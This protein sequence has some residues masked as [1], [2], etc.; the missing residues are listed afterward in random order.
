MSMVKDLMSR[1]VSAESAGIVPRFFSLL[2]RHQIEWR[3]NLASPPDA[4]ILHAILDVEKRAG[5]DG[6]NNL[7]SASETGM[8]G[9]QGD[10]VDYHRR[11]QAKARSKVEKLAVKLTAAAKR[12]EP[13]EE[14]NRLRDIPSKCQASLNRVLVEFESKGALPR[15]QEASVQQVSK[16]DRGDESKDADSNRFATTAIFIVLMLAVLAMATLA[17]GSNLLWGG[18]AGSLLDADPAFVIAAV[19]VLL[20]FVIAVKT[21]IQPGVPL[22][23]ERLTFRVTML[24]I[25][26]FLVLLA[27]FCAHLIII[28][29]DTQAFAAAD[30]VAAI[31][32]MISDPGAIGADINALKGFGVVMVMGLLGMLLGNGVVSSDDVN[33]L[34]RNADPAAG[35]HGEAN[36][37]Q[38]RKR[39]NDIVDAS[40]KE[41]DRSVE[42]LQKQLNKLSR[43]AEKAKDSQVLYD[44]FL[45]GLEESCNLLLERYRELNT[46]E[47]NTDIPPS[48]AE[49]ICFRMEG[50]SR[51]L[52]FED[53]I[54][55]Q[56]KSHQEMQALYGTVAEIRRKLRDLDRVAIRSLDADELHQEAE[57]TF[58]NSQLGP[59]GA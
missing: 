44:N 31:N 57:E 24:L 53:G 56:Q 58:A 55:R 49:Q 9:S 47:R 30:V 14:A 22:A 37:E 23:R 1:I 38:L 33:R 42:R 5:A 2:R 36:A 19:A 28:S 25:T 43:L 51:V 32:A 29:A 40:E 48:F 26:A 6:R 45:A 39:I 8:T 35:K 12:V 20:P 15:E 52:F 46:A 7:P 13:S 4:D 18:D 27:L 59:V 10:I 41:V 50:A 54:E 11:L 34:A 16:K 17:L 3:L 21:S